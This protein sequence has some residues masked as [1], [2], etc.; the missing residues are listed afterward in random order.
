MKSLKFSSWKM[1]AVAL[2]LAGSLLYA[3]QDN[4]QDDTNGVNNTGSQTSGD[5]I[6]SGMEGTRDQSSQ[7]GTGTV[8]DTSAGQ[9]GTGGTGTGDTGTGTGGTGTGGSGTG[10]GTGTGSGGT[11]TGGSGTGGSGTGS[12]TGGSGTGGSGTGS[13]T[14]TGTGGSGTTR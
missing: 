13:G 5:S 8:I 11:G 10:S 6:H 7:S 12:G 3:C 2:I 9:S 1:N 14:G 4:S